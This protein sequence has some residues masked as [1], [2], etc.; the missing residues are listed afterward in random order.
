MLDTVARYA[1][2]LTVIIAA[3]SVFLTVRQW[4]HA[5][6]LTVVTE[7]VEMIQNPEFTRAIMHILELPVAAEPKL[8]GGDRGTM[9]AAYLVS[10]VFESLGVMVFYR[11]VPLHI[12]DHLIGG[13]VR[14]S[15]VRLALHV[16]DRRGEF[17]PMFGEW[18]QWLA[19]R[20]E[21]SPAPGK[22]VGAA[23]A[24]VRW[25]W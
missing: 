22:D 9:T 6:S 23:A 8:V 3:T 10:H 19:E 2:L 5:Q 4:K 18:F 12:V 25:R 16:E 1:T 15:W 24:Y 11:V 21:E 13:Y 7:L 14:A 17:G 20:L